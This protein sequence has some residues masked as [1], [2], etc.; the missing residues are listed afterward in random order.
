[1]ITKR[2]W[3]QI[4][5]ATLDDC[6]YAKHDRTKIL[7]PETN[8]FF[9][10]TASGVL[11]Y[12]TDF[13]QYV[14]SGQVRIHREDITRLSERTIHLANGNMLSVD[15]LITATGFSAKPTVSF[16]PSTIHSDLGL[17]STQLTKSQQSFWEDLM[18]KASLRIEPR[19][20]R[21]LV[22]PFA[23]PFSSDRLQYN[24]GIDPD[25]RYTPWRLYRGIAPPGPTSQGQHNLAFIGMFSNIA[26][27]LRLELQCLW[28]YAYLNGRLDIDR[29]NVFD[30]TAL[31]TRWAEARSPFGHGRYFPDVVFDQ[32]PYFDTL[33]RDLGVESRRKS[34]WFKEIFEP[35]GQQDYK[36]VV[37]EWIAKQRPE[38]LVD[39]K[40]PTA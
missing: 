22:A 18:I 15:A 38:D 32:L 24:P 12:E 35:Y 25:M 4:G 26:N 27:T 11:S 7:I 17:P 30:E 23:G 1:M 10:G 5:T 40:I 9:Y 21:F 2:F 19:F 31:V 39:M 16:A 36:T 6:G 8:P 3:V 37:H 34:T 29:H 14:K 28:A 13:F 33:L 20:P